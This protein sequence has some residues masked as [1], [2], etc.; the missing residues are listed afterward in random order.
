MPCCVVGEGLQFTIMTYFSLF[1]FTALLSSMF[2]TRQQ[3][4]LVEAIK[5]RQSG[6]EAAVT[7]ILEENRQRR[8][9]RR[10]QQHELQEN[11]KFHING[12]YVSH[13]NNYN[14]SLKFSGPFGDKCP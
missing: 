3:G 1:F 7:N 6:N 13:N 5:A 9:V 11:A 12:N 4:V 14:K 10:Q 8:I 2:V